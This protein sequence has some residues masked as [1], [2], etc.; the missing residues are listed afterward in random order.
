MG[1]GRLR[2]VGKNEVLST[3]ALK[4]L[5]NPPGFVLLGGVYWYRDD[6][7]SILHPSFG[8]AFPI[9]LMHKSPQKPFPLVSPQNSLSSLT[10]AG[11]DGSG[12]S[13]K[14]KGKG[15]FSH[16]KIPAEQPRLCLEAGAGFSG[17]KLFPP[18]PPPGWW[19]E[20]VVEMQLQWGEPGAD[21]WRGNRGMLGEHP[22]HRV[23]VWVPGCCLGGGG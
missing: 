18:P 22:S 14:N 11:S 12:G 13:K 10:R 3:L 15:S 19:E 4:L 6:P 8:A 16:L 17:A 5:P 21:G 2:A 1:I 9:S 20:V 7:P 23:W